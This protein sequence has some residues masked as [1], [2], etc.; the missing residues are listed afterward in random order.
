M[1]IT[2]VGDSALAWTTTSVAATVVAARL[3]VR[4]KIRAVGS[5]D[6]FMLLALAWA[7]S[8]AAISQNLYS[9]YPTNHFYSADFWTKHTIAPICTE[10]SVL[11]SKTSVGILLLR[12]LS[13]TLKW[14]RGLIVALLAGVWFT[15]F[16]VL[17]QGLLPVC[18]GQKYSA[19]TMAACLEES[20]STGFF[21]AWSFFGM[22]VDFVFS[23]LPA[24]VF[25]RLTISRS[26]KISLSL[27]MGLGW[28][29]SIFTLLK[30]ISPYTYWSADT[31]NTVV[32]VA[33]YMEQ[34]LVM[35][36]GSLATLTPLYRYWRTGK[37]MQSRDHLDGPAYS[38]TYSHNGGTR[39]AVLA[40]NSMSTVNG[41][42]SVDENAGIRVDCEF[43]VT[44]SKQ[45]QSLV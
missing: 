24:F 4:I 29:A 36:C 11:C 21:E 41:G 34:A 28:I 26:R 40:K 37:L 18:S 7:I 43:N 17:L 27:L 3:F 10:L 23:S 19:T 13:T 38:S 30:A 25:S 42:R 9:N 12:A 35:I 14:H 15:T 2:L 5:D 44:S 31:I 39:H 45:E 33:T 20:V 16:L 8:A 22:L 6:Y 1:S 32:P